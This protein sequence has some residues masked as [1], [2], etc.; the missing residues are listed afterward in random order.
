[1]TDA[2]HK[3]VYYETDVLGN[4]TCALC[5]HACFIAPG[6]YGRCQARRNDGGRLVAAAYGRIT[7]M[8]V[9]PVEKKPL[10]HFLP[11]ADILSIGSFGCNLSCRFCQNHTIS[12]ARA[13]TTALSPDGLVAEMRRARS[14]GVAYTYNEPLINFEYLQDACRAVRDAGGKNVLVT[15][16]YVNPEPFEKLLPL[17]DAMNI[18]VKAFEDEYYRQLCGGELV[19]VLRT[20][21][22]AV[23]S[24]HVELTLLVIP[25]ANDAPK[26]NED[27]ARWIVEHAGRDTPLHLSAY[28]PRYQYHVGPT[29][30]STLERLRDLYAQHLRYVYLGNLR[31]GPW[32]DTHCP[33]CAATVIRRSDA[34]A[35][36]DLSGLTPQSA[37]R[38]CGTKL[39]IVLT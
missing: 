12:Q 24:T 16:G 18:D 27:F 21:E 14:P 4:V 32:T 29:Q 6:K 8:H 36:V 31:P 34:D 22:R 7:A 30:P 11:G 35:R 37:C 5:P 1:M 23:A 25:G 13:D 20:V 3:A 9:D 10:Y 19:H 17:V 28:F 33:E 2:P 38:A 39:P 15:N 26:P